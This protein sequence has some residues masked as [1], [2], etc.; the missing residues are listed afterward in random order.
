VPVK[1]KTAYLKVRTFTKIASIFLALMALIHA[2]RI[3]MGWSVKVEGVTVPIWASLI[4]LVV[5]GGL[6]WGLWKESCSIKK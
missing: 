4:F 6:A 1:S 3:I 2:F 5:D